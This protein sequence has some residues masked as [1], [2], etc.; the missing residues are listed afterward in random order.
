MLTAILRLACA[1]CFLWLAAGFLFGCTSAQRVF[2]L[3]GAT[4]AGKPPSG[5]IHDYPEAIAAIIS[6]TGEMGLPTPDGVATLYSNYM[7]LEAALLS[8]LEKDAELIEQRLDPKA[9]EK[10]R[11]GKDERLALEARQLATTAHAVAMHK[12]VFINELLFVRY[13]WYERTRILAHEIAHVI[14]KGLVDGRPSAP[15]RWLQEGFADWVAYK[16]QDKLGY[17]TF[18][19]SRENNVDAVARATAFQTFPSL[20]Q[21]NTGPDWLT[22]VRTLGRAATYGQAFLA[23]DFW[24]EQKGLSA[25]VEY[26]R[27]FNKVFN[28]EKN[29]AA[30]TGEP[31]KT[32]EEKFDRYLRKL[33]GK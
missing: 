14:E 21:L 9:R 27:L 18:A 3:A 1:I 5:A 26:F 8:E 28:R 19:K 15:G 17:E 2:P 24:I 12:R 10:F 25:M 11:A 4:P 6:I 16:V 32:F 7:Q 33:L 13:P 31:M 22:W 23:V 20:S 29:F 30:A